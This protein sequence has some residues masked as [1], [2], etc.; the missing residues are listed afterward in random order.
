MNKNYK[1]SR[2]HNLAFLALKTDKTLKN[3][4]IRPWE[5]N[6]AEVVMLADTH[7]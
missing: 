2:I 4:E 5:E 7:P 1:A 6:V 3:F